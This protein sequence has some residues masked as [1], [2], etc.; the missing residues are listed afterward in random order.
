MKE[1]LMGKHEIIF[2]QK[3]NGRIPVQ[4]FLDGLPKD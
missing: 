2:Y 4:E 1:D 3:D